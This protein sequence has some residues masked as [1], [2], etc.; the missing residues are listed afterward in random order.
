MHLRKPKKLVLLWHI[1]LIP[2]RFVNTFFFLNN[3][4]V[5]MMDFIYNE[6]N[7][8]LHSTTRVFKL[9][10][11]KYSTKPNCIQQ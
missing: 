4:S 5:A 2:T 7:R 1:S 6:K 8:Q 3:K 11:E 10:T 9:V